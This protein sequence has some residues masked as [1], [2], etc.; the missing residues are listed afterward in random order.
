MYSVRLK[1]RAGRSRGRDPPAPDAVGTLSRDERR[2]VELARRIGYGTILK[3]RVQGGKPVLGG[4][5]R[6]RRKYRLGRDDGWRPSAAGR[7]LNL[8][9]QQRELIEKLRA[10]DDGLVTIEVQDG[11]P[12][13]VTVE[14]DMDV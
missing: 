1:T 13:F 10:T 8:H 2:L 9:C 12:V 14:H 3:L 7:A 11:L 6:V 5:L 4:K